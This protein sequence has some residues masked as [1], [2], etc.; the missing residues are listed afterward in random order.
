MR[1]TR[2]A[3]KALAYKSAGNIGVAYTYNE[4]L[5]GWEYVRDTAVL[6]KK[7][8]TKKCAGDKWYCGT[9]DIRGTFA[10]Y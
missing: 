7:S 4:P 2:L 3:N 10:L 8:R 5:I 6:V 9:F 1:L